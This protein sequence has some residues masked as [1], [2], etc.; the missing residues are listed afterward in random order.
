[1]RVAAERASDGVAGT[2]HATVEVPDFTRD[3]LSLSGVAIGRGD[4]RRIAARQEIEGLLPFAPTAVRAFEASDRVGALLRVHQGSSRPV[5]ATMTT[6]IAD[7]MG[8]VLF[9]RS[10]E[11]A[12]TVFSN[13]TAEHRFEIP[14]VDI[15]PGT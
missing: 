1:V 10:E 15:P 11:I 8:A 14:L 6:S 7:S 5:A 13:G 4:G 12:P 3:A 9:T 2:V